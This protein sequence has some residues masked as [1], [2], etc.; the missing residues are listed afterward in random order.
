MSL[1]DRAAKAI[2]SLVRL[3]NQRVINPQQECGDY[4]PLA[5]YSPLPE[6]GDGLARCQETVVSVVIRRTTHEAAGAGMAI[7]QSVV[8]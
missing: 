1:I 5:S 4:D 8:L 3:P 2:P 6:N 7:A